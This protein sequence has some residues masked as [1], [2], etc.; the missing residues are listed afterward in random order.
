M[1]GITTH[2]M[3]YVRPCGWCHGALDIAH[4]KGWPRYRQEIMNSKI[5]NNLFV[6]TVGYEN[7]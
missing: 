6:P 2:V 4:G 7:I 1:Y 5:L 3:S